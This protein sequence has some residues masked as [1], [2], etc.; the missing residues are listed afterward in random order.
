MGKRKTPAKSSKAKQPTITTHALPLPKK[1]MELVGKQIGVPGAWW[2]GRMSAEE[3]KTLYKCTV[4]DF[5]LLHKFPWAIAPEAAVS[6]QEMGVSGT[7]S[8]EH[9]DASGEVFWMQYN[10]TFLK[11]Y[12]DTFPGELP[13]PAKTPTVDLEPVVIDGSTDTSSKPDVLDAFP[14]VRLG[15][16]PVMGCFAITADTLVEMGSKAGQYKAT[17]ECNIEHEDGTICGARR[18]IYHKKDR[19]VSTSNLINH[20]YR[21]KGGEHEEDE[22]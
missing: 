11:F 16:A 19:A 17:F 18:E 5:K 14:H 8:T 20:K 6:L 12:Y 13:S 7:G 1:P 22:E 2:E 9:G 3:K 15:R 10:P 4:R 21:G